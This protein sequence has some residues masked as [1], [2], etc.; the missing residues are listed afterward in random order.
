MKSSRRLTLRRETLTELTCDELA[1][2]VAG[3]VPT[4]QPGCS[5]DDVNQF[6]EDVYW[7]LSL[8]QH[9][10]VTCI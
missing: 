10:T 6:V 8:H 2:A 1:L 3:A 5:V 7:R 9:C 4:L